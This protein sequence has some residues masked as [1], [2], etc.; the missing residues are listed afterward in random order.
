MRSES[1]L[2]LKS[3]NHILKAPNTVILSPH[4][5]NSLV[6]KYLD[7]C[8]QFVTNSLKSDSQPYTNATLTRGHKLLTPTPQI[9]HTPSTKPP[10]RALNQ[11][12]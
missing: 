4:P 5:L 9:T 12:N 1:H 2:N 7:L 6:I 10:R 11:Q 3:T 8:S